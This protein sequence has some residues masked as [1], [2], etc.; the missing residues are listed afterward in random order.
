M[1][2]KPISDE[3]LAELDAIAMSAHDTRL[4]CGFVSV[5]EY[6][7]LRERLRLAE[8]VAQA[9]D[10]IYRHHD[11]DCTSLTVNDALIAW[12]SATSPGEKT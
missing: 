6:L 7:A 11:C 3:Q 4:G 10:S 9:L 2:V 12:R 5:A 1:T 8:A